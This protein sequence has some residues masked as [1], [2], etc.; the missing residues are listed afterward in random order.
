[1]I[2]NVHK[3]KQQSCKRSKIVQKNSW[4]L[5]T[6]PNGVTHLIVSL[7][8]DTPPPLKMA[9]LEIYYL[10]KHLIYK[11]LAEKVANTKIYL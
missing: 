7:V 6:L 9:F 2:I 5:N 11:K 10:K 3:N 1:M 8:D 4:F